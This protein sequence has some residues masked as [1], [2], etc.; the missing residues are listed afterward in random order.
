MKIIISEQQLK[1]IITE[2]RYSQVTREISMDLMKEIKAF[3]KSDDEEIDWE[4][5]YYHE[6][7]DD[8]E[9]TVELYLTKTDSE[10]PFD[11]NGGYKFDDENYLNIIDFTIDINPKLFK[12]EQI[13]KLLAELKDTIRH[14]IEHISQTENPEKDVRNK[15]YNSFAQE[16]L[17]PR[18]LPAYI[19][20]FYTQAKTR[21]MYM[22]DVIDEWAND[23]KDQFKNKKEMDKVKDKLIDFGKKLLPQA[24]WK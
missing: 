2:G 8:E 7:F 13:N 9:F 23:R 24:K 21:K 15:V 3:L 6:S 10:I 20:G 16:V 4:N 17:I 12:G 18:E 22:N 19:Q 14:E 5:V 11:I 1:Y